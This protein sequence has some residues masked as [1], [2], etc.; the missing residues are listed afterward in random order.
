MPA[1]LIRIDAGGEWP[2]VVDEDEKVLSTDGARW[3]F[4]A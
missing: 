3:R 1:V 2:V 4:V